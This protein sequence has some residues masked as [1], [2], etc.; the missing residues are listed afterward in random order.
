MK[1]ETTC[2]QHSDLSGFVLAGSSNKKYVVQNDSLVA[3][4]DPVKTTHKQL[5]FVLFNDSTRVH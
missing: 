1:S 3:G 2:R 5:K 4:A